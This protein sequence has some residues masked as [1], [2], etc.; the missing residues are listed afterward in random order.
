MNF[1][2]V[3]MNID[4][5]FLFFGL[6]SNNLD[7]NLFT[8]LNYMAM[9]T[10]YFI[11]TLFLLLSVNLQ[12]Q[13]WSDFED[14]TGDGAPYPSGGNPW[15]HWGCG[16]GTGCSITCSSNYAHNGDYSGL[17]PGDGTTDAVLDLGNQI[18]GEW[19][20]EF[21]VYIPSGKE[22]YWNLQGVVP[23]GS[24]EWI[25][26]NIFFN[27]DTTN[28]GV[29]LIDDTALGEINF[30]FPHDQWF[31]IVMN[32]DFSFGMSL[33]TWQFNVDGIDVVP[34]GTPFTRFDGTPATSLGGIDFFS[35]SANNELYVDD[36][37]FING[38]I[39]PEPAPQPFTDDM[40]YENGAPLG[41]W[42]STIEITTTQANSGT[43]SGLIPD[44]GT[45]D[46]LLNLGNATT[47]IWDLEFYMFVPSNREAYWNIQGQ[48]PVGAGEWVVG[49]F[50]FNQDNANPGVGTI[51]DT[52]IG[53]VSF[54][55]PHDTWF[56]INMSFNLIQGMSNAT[57]S[58]SVDNNEVLPEETPFTNSNGD[59][60]TS[61]GGI[62]F[63]SI[64]MNNELY[65][66]DF[67]YSEQQLSTNDYSKTSFRL[68]PNP[69]DEI[70]QIQSNREIINIIIY[71]IFGK[72]VLETT[73]S[74]NIN[75]SK[76]SKGLYF[77]TIE[78]DTEKGI[79][80]LIKK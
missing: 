46:V 48:V 1:D 59:I 27:Q 14:C 31:R 42:W 13:F 51:D 24:G 33:A 75:I 3:F 8:N 22:A 43:R 12:A 54:T 66:D 35:I 52:N 58:I 37:I 74:E 30:N 80:K 68:Y 71:D 2:L 64:S 4:F 26:G 32:F 39:D 70:I 49:N 41:D 47:G 17:I 9:K 38:F 55:F 60:P 29:G 40:E 77:V 16:G 21:W 18:F 10:N 79:Q 67:I 61:L 11:I 78:T 44:D 65:L 76:L 7:K 45:T 34:M 15:T 5:T 20:L 56:P 53:A 28:P 57:W 19:G 72:I 23:I 62:D 36:F 69:S 50:F 73:T 6:F 25:V 63:F